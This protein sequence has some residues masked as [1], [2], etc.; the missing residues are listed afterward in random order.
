MN[1]TEQNSV[2]FLPLSSCSLPTLAVA[3]AMALS[4][5]GGHRYRAPSGNGRDVKSAE[6]LG[7]R[8]LILVCGNQDNMGTEDSR[9]L[10]TPQESFFHFLSHVYV[11]PSPHSSIQQRAHGL[12]V[13]ER[14]TDGPMFH[15]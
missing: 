7:V 4:R 6:S 11:Y 15:L 13:R 1:R 12:K 10:R 8:E 14:L 9:L 5:L 3:S 2:D